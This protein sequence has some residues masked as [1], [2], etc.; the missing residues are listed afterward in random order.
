MRFQKQTF[1]SLEEETSTSPTYPDQIQTG[2]NNQN[3]NHS[4]SQKPKISILKESLSTDKENFRYEETCQRFIEDHSYDLDQLSKVKYSP[5]DKEKNS[6]R[7]NQTQ[8]ISDLSQNLRDSMLFDQQIDLQPGQ[9]YKTQI[10][11]KNELKGKFMGYH[12]K[13]KPMKQQSL[14]IDQTADCINNYNHDFVDSAIKQEHSFLSK[15]IPVSYYLNPESINPTPMKKSTVNDNKSIGEYGNPLITPCFFQNDSPINNFEPTPC[16]SNFEDDDEQDEF[17]HTNGVG[18]DDDQE[19]E[20]QDSPNELNS[21]DLQEGND[22]L[23][24]FEQQ[25]KNSKSRFLE[26]SPIKNLDEDMP[27]FQELISH[28]LNYF[29][30]S[31]QIVRDIQP[32]KQ[33]HKKYHDIQAQYELLQQH[34]QVEQKALELR[35]ANLEE[36]FISKDL[37]IIQLQEDISYNQ[38]VNQ[39]LQEKLEI[40]ES[41][42][43]DQEG[44]IRELLQNQY[45]MGSIY[46]KTKDRKQKN[47]KLV[48]DIFEM[49]PN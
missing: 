9:L 31:K 17:Y 33:V 24:A 42:I 44:Q 12:R 20:F 28:A 16:Q 18:E 39:A 34:S 10:F 1:G 38:N 13:S 7:L 11:R 4:S 47:Q 2:V 29:R 45:K 19:Q 14:T 21:Q 41:K 22:R 6:L 35:C 5:F 15:P 43:K 27:S 48:F 37:E 8:R 49:Q 3:Y 26:N 32:F 46:E 23:F 40:L 25:H 36:Q 30:D